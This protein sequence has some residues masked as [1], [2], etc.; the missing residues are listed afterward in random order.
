MI[1]LV[2]PRAEGIRS[3]GLSFMD[4]N[5]LCCFLQYRYWDLVWSFPNLEYLTL[6][7]PLRH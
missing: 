6:T 5:D 4:F 2:L 1:Q 3:L 7:P